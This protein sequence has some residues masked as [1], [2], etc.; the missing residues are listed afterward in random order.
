MR[1][2]SKTSLSI[3]ESEVFFFYNFR[4]VDATTLCPQFRI[5]WPHRR[6]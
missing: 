4:G 3:S 1:M 6:T 2:K 5:S